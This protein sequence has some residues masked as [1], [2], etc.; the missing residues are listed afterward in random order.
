MNLKINVMNKLRESLEKD[1]DDYM[2]AA[3]ITDEFSK[4]DLVNQLLNTYETKE[5]Y[6]KIKSLYPFIGN[7]ESQNQ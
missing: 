3:G 4:E 7:E 1:A 2:K 6:D 5:K